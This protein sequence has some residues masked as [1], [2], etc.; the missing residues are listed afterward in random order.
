M[1]KVEPLSPSVED[2]NVAPPSVDRRKFPHCDE[3]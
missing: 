2:E 1:N 3:A